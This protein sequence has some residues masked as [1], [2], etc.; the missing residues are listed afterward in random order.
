MLPAQELLLALPTIEERHAAFFAQSQPIPLQV[1]RHEDRFI[2]C[3]SLTPADNF[4]VEMGYYI[5][6]SHQGKGIM[7][8]AGRKLLQFAANEFG[9]EKVYSSADIHNVA[10]G[11]V[12]DRLA[13]ET[14]NGKVVKSTKDS[15]WPI[16]KKVEGR[17]N[18]SSSKTW[19]WA[20]KPQ[21]IFES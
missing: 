14:A 18:P 20:I 2:G 19:T 3:I 16:E 7:K 21:E 6:P 1:I 17:G 10:S 11:K 15:T 4:T 9:I 5:H 12:I 8:A 13:T